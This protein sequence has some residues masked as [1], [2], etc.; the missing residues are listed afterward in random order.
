MVFQERIGTGE[1]PSQFGVNVGGFSHQNPR[2]R[3]GEAIDPGRRGSVFVDG[4]SGEGS[5]S[6]I[7][8][9]HEAGGRSASKIRLVP[10]ICQAAVSEV[11]SKE[12]RG[13]SA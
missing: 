12:N 11:V 5:I 4:N 6:V 9:G 8:E 7:A 10:L 2:T 3:I 13:Y 1:M